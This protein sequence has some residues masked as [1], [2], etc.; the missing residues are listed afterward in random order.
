MGLKTT[1]FEGPP[2]LDALE[3]RISDA[4]WAGDPNRAHAVAEH[5][6][7]AFSANPHRYLSYE[8]V[9]RAEKYQHFAGMWSVTLTLTAITKFK[10]E[11]RERK[12]RDRKANRKGER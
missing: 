3:N 9:E 5:L 1:T 6:R 11:E 12:A 10:K 4:I 2:T 8:W 7:I